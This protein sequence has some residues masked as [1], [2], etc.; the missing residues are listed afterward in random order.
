MR[1]VLLKTILLSCL[2]LLQPLVLAGSNVFPLKPPGKFVNLG[3]HRLYFDCRGFKTPTVV[4][5][6]GLGESSANWLPLLDALQDETRVCVY[7][8][9]GYGWSDTG[10]GTRTTAQITYELHA[11]LELAE[12]P[13]PYVLVGHS[14]GGFTAQYF[15]RQ[16]P[17]ET[18]GVV[19]VESSHPDQVR[20][21]AKLDENSAGKELIIG[22]HEP[23]EESLS[24]LQKKWHYLNSSRKAVFAQMDELK[25]FP[26][27]A[28]QVRHAGPF[29][30][31]PLAV[32]SRGKKLLPSVDGK[33]LEDEWIGMQNE[34]AR[35]SPYSWHITITGSGH[36]VY[37]DA[38]EI[39]VEN[40]TRIVV[41][42]RI[43][44]RA[45]ISSGDTDRA[46]E[47]VRKG[48]KNEPAGLVKIP[49]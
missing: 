21:L 26:E 5:D 41:Q 29:P 8:R 48:M 30:A 38:P 11:L 49:R 24:E 47:S 18:V 7:D 39:I 27:S 9:A 33:S 46:P 20:R 17:G 22:R 37:K 2:L 25:H 35:L 6:V 19:L 10:P 15:A 40:I 1:H 31:I 42:A 28:A 23:P 3:L 13:G 34:L 36:S 12:I 44:M 14:F 43:G 45:I 16:Y 4:I 32:L